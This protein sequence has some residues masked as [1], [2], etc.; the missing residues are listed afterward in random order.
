MSHARK[1]HSPRLILSQLTVT[2]EDCSPELGVKEQVCYGARCLIGPFGSDCLAFAKLTSIY[3]VSCE[4]HFHLYYPHAPPLASD[5]SP[6]LA[7][8]IAECRPFVRPRLRLL[9]VE[10]EADI[11]EEK[12]A[13]HAWMQREVRRRTKE[14]RRERRRRAAEKSRVGQEAAQ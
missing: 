1:R 11:A 14:E 12:R 3:T 2:S 5:G 7:E 4:P 6:S 10:V 9:P 8:P 13:T